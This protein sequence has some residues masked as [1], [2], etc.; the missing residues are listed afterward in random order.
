MRQTIFNVCRLCLPWLLCAGMAAG[1]MAARRDLVYRFP[2]QNH[3]LLEG[4]GEDFYMYCDRT[5]EGEKSTPWQAGGYGMVRNPF[6]ASDGKI[7]FSKMHEGVDIK[8]M[9]RDAQGEPLDLVYPIAP[10]KVAYTSPSPQLSN[11]GRY[12]VVSH[13]VPEGTIYSL[14]AHLA[15]V[16]CVVGQTVGTANALG[17]MGHSGAGIDKRRSH[18]HLE[19]CLMIHSCYDRFSPPSNKHGIFNGMN[20][21]GIDPAPV[22]RACS[23]G[24]PLSLNEH[25]NTL[26][27]HYR[28]RVPTHG[29]TPDFLRRYPFLY[30]GNNAAPL[31][32]AVD[33]AFTAEG[34][35]LAVYPATGKVAQPVVVSCISL[36]TPQ[37]NVTVNRVK[38]S[39]VNAA[40]TASGLRYISHFFWHKP[41]TPATDPV[42]A[43]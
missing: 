42:T 23:E 21:V 34:V 3:A 16:D 40:L 17:R 4:R 20:L 22:L 30:K 1:E 11:Y 10:G 25:W 41:A 6:R 2:T 18:V 27:E 43:L 9:Q 29:H 15:R 36:P 33:V 37:Q 5:F 19:I 32:E 35:P 26:K 38:N 14:Y 13:E 12:V 28:V 31:P 7:M 39:S 24:T 8:P